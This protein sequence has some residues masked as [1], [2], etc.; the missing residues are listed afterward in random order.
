MRRAAWV[1]LAYMWRRSRP[2]AALVFVLCGLSNVARAQPARFGIILGNNEGAAT[3]TTLA[4]AERDATRV[5]SVLQELGRFAPE[6]TVLLLGAS[7]DEARS[8]LIRI[9]ERIRR[10]G[11]GATLF[12]YYSGHGDAE[13]LHMGRSSLSLRELK[14]LTAGSSATLRVLVVDSCQ[15]GS[16]TRPK[17]GRVVA[18]F[19]LQADAS[20]GDGSVYLSSSAANE[21]S[22]ESDDIQG[23]FFTH[24]FVSGLLGAADSNADGNVD[25]SEAYRYVYQNTLR[26]SSRSEAGLQHPGFR[27]DYAGQG[28]FVLTRPGERDSKRGQVTFPGGR[29]YLI[30]QGTRT[31]AIVAEVGL[32]DPRRTV[33]LR[34]G[35]Y[36]I[37][38]RGAEDI[39]EGNWAVRGD[40]RQT[41]SLTGMSRIDYARLVRRGGTT[42]DKTHGITV[43][44]LTRS[45]T[46]TGA[47]W[48]FGLE[49]SYALDLP[50]LTLVASLTFLRTQ[51]DNPLVE[52]TDDEYSGTF[53]ALWLWDLGLL[54]LGMGPYVGGGITYQRY[55]TRGRAPSRASGVGLFGIAAV[56]ALDV[57]SG[58][59]LELRTGMRTYVGRFQTNKTVGWGARIALPIALGVSKRF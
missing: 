33:S 2:L 23:S 15:S 52:T 53:G 4:Y 7:A 29:T 45:S 6:N 17:G 56:A 43:A 41:L 42:L 24:Y 21:V 40:T 47:P 32:R 38:A 58:F 44:A 11:A 54:T 57:G 19:V 51:Y 55:E 22:Q 36:F 30:Q 26:A 34:Q 12:V 46:H 1:Q 3:E 25:L 37:V 18:P 49:A 50:R 28:D 14:S 31:G 48:S 20:L 16:L 13:A 9:N 5:H 27:Y 35:S 10:E 8:T 39:Y 59:S